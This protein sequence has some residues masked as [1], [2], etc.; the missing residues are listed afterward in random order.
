Q[1]L[2]HATFAVQVTDVGGASTSATTNTFSVAP[3]GM[4]IP[5]TPELDPASNSGIDKTKAI[6]NVTMPTIHVAAPSGTV[7]ELLVNGVSTVQAT[8][9]ATGTAT[10]IIGPLADGAYSL[11]AAVAL[12]AGNH[13]PQSTALGVTIDTLPPSVPTFDLAPG[14]ADL[15]SETTS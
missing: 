10:F 5:G 7:L 15:G 9:D 8:A 4:V 11:T 1:A 14:T 12:G 2:S 6:T 3:A 13:G